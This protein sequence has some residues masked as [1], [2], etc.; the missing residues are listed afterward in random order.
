MRTIQCLKGRCRWHTKVTHLARPLRLG[1]APWRADSVRVWCTC[2]R[3]AGTHPNPP[4]PLNGGQAKLGTHV[5]GQA[6]PPPQRRALRP[7]DPA[8]SGYAMHLY[9]TGHATM[10]KGTFREPPRTPRGWV[11]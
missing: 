7:R 8:K 10:Y 4:S 11:P 1:T 6:K 9:R 5:C 3:K 2:P